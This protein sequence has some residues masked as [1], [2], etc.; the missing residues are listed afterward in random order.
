[1]AIGTYEL[2]LDH[3]N[4]TRLAYLDSMLSLEYTRVLHGVGVMNLT[5]P[6][7]FDTSLLQDDYKIE[8][9]R[10]LPGIPKRLENVYMIRGWRKWT[11]PVGV[12]KTLITGVDGNDIL[13]RRFCL[14]QNS[15]EY[16]GSYDYSRKTGYAGNMIKQYMRDT[17]LTPYVTG[18]T[19]R[20]T[21]WAFA[22]RAIV[23]YF[24]I[25]GD[26]N[27]GASFA[28]QKACETI[29]DIANGICDRSTG[30]GSPLYWYVYP[31]SG[32]MYQLRT[33][34]PLMGQDLSSQIVISPDFAMGQATHERDATDEFT[35]VYVRGKI[36][37]NMGRCFG[38]SWNAARWATNPFCYRELFVDLGDAELAECRERAAEEVP[39][40]DNLPQEYLSCSLYE[41]E[42]LRYQRE[43]DLGDKVGL[44]YQGLQDNVIIKVI[45]IQVGETEKVSVVIKREQPLEVE[46]G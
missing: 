24:T 8:V 36:I 16:S 30:R 11:D 7:S 14:A 15:G 10:A 45:Q 42:A 21:A 4:G 9:W 19:G 32:A 20:A 33:Y 12:D 29:F 22:Y 34:A 38:I 18:N 27:D 39:S 13:K 44:N 23:P 43:W 5:M 28:E 37:S 2:W 26:A 46:I 41:M 3:W 6:S 25:Q 31:V 35:M 1:M 17:L 40:A